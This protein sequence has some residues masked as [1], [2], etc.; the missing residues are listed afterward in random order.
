M[1][2]KPVIVSRDTNMDKMVLEAESGLVVTYGDLSALEAAL[3]RLSTDKELCS[4]L[5]M[6]A[7]RAYETRFSRKIMN[8]RLLSLY[9]EIQEEEGRD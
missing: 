2:G 5:G 9:T 3:L 7:R 4:Q 1:L 8:D 6:N